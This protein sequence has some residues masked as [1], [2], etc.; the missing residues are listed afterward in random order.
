M[1]RQH[2][3]TNFI[4]RSTL[5][6]ILVSD[7]HLNERPSDQ[8]R[9]GL[10]A[11]LVENKA[12]ADELLILGDLT[13]AKDRHSSQL[14][15]RLYSSTMLLEEH[16]RVIILK[17]NHDYVDPSHPFFEFL[18]SSSDTRFIKDP[19]QLKLSIGSALFLPAGAEWPAKL[20][21]TDYI[22]THA[23][24]SGAK[25]ENG[26]SLTGVDPGLV[27]DYA[28]KVLS[29]DIH[30]PQKIGRNIEYVGAPYHT[31]FGDQFEPRVLYVS[32][33]G[34]QTDWHFDAPYKHMLDISGPG[35]LHT[36]EVSADDHVKV[37]CHLRR[38]DY[39]KWREYRQQ[40]REIAAERHWKL[41]GA[42]VV[43]LDPGVRADD[44][45]ERAA[46]M[47]VKSPD[48]LLV[49]YVKRQHA[50]D[51]HLKLCREWLRG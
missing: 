18:G 20:P 4:G 33:G 30:V 38:A 13:D 51:D 6:A 23:T 14:V 48:E 47:Q 15:N 10:F 12:D 41:F 32:N 16:F 29:G 28:G 9:W 25:A 37:R 26:Q 36:V 1:S 34:K 17:G 46:T 21:K 35:D 5:S 45:A 49:D 22:F 43:P 50:S 2:A 3:T 24:F 11:W 8:Y 44:P 42:E 31:R 39:V 19:E 7:L 27:R 40:I